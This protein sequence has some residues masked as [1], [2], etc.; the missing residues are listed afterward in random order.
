MLAVTG[1]VL[2][3]KIGSGFI[4][5]YRSANREIGGK[6]TVAEMEKVIEESLVVLRGL[7]TEPDLDGSGF[8][9]LENI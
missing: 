1:A 6:P 2:D 7:Q 5:G 3:R 8:L 9:R 4:P